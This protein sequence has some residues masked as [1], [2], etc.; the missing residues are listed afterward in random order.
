MCSRLPGKLRSKLR[1]VGDLPVK[2]HAGLFECRHPLATAI[3]ETPSSMRSK[4]KMRAQLIAKST[5]GTT[6]TAMIFRRRE[7]FGAAKLI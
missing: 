1:I 2:E 6:R 5:E 7:K 3:Y 4:R